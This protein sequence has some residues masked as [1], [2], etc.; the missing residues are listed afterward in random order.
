[1]S[2]LRDAP[3]SR[4]SRVMTRPCFVSPPFTSGAVALRLCRAGWDLMLFL[5][6]APPLRAER[7]VVVDKAICF[8]LPIRAL[9]A[10]GDGTS[11]RHCRNPAIGN[12]PARGG[13]AHLELTS[14]PSRGHHSNAP[15]APTVQT[16]LR[17]LS[18]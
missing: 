14:V 6:A 10:V 16:C 18:R 12:K 9:H 3:V 4:P 15:F 5:P 8:A 11:R 13:R 1:M 17:K 2:S 7:A